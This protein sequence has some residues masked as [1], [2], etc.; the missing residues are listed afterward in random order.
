MREVPS[1]IEGL[2]WISNVHPD[3]LLLIPGLDA[4]TIRSAAEGDQ[5]ALAQLHTTAFCCI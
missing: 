4:E 5:Q 2:A 1:S 3:E